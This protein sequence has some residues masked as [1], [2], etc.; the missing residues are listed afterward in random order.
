MRFS[1]TAAL[2]S[3]SALLSC[4]NS[5]N[6]AADEDESVE[7]VRKAVF[8][9][10]SSGV[11]EVSTTELEKLL[12]DGG[13]VVLDT[14]PHREWSISHI[15]TALNVA[16]KPG[17]PMALYTS[18]AAEVGRLVDGDK[19][20]PLVLYC[21]G[22]YCGKSKR[23]AGALLEEGYTDVRR[24]QLGAPVWRALVGVMVIEPEGIRHVF[25]NDQTAVWID[26]RE[27]SQFQEGSI[28]GARSLPQSAVLPGKDVGEVFAAKN[29]G[30]LPMEDHN[31]RIVVFGRD[32]DQA[33]EVAE[34][35]AREAFHNVTY[36]DGAYEELKSLTDSLAEST[37]PDVQVIER[38][39]K[40]WVEATNEKDIAKWSSFLANNPYF[41]PADS[42]PLNGR[43]AVLAYYE[44]SFSDPEFS[45]GC[46]QLEVRISKSGDMAWSRG[47]CEATYTMPDG[48]VGR[49]S[50]R[51]LKV[52]AKYPDG[53]WRCHI[54]H[55]KSA[56]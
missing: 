21:N 47:V 30:R 13:A 2:L 26:V 19:T 49:G 51:W 25:A 15:P 29:D 3:V 45:L 23:V 9:E 56:N 44:K 35:L 53:S 28:P 14:R 1:R 16:P 32:G 24:Y 12:R 38:T 33:G 52:W 7:L 10:P 5:D 43:D 22:P 34:A 27:S 31:T 36:F 6:V 8:A 42:P 48:S 4:S 20:Q 46:E 17:I 50:S 11:L 55:W 54:N 39:Y 37:D 40:A 18:D 41:W